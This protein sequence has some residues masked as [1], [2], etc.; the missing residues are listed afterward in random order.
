MR[1][2]NGLAKNTAAPLAETGLQSQSQRLST[3]STV[4]GGLF[5]PSVDL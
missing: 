3:S 4:L 2:K 1:T 5:D